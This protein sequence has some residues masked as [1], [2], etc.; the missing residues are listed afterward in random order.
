MA[1]HEPVPM[2][3]TIEILSTLFFFMELMILSVPS[4]SMVLPTSD[5]RPADVHDVLHMKIMF[6]EKITLKIFDTRCC[7]QEN[8]N[9]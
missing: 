8:A 7:V 2:D 5:V 4:R 6:Q 9:L 3:V 1:V